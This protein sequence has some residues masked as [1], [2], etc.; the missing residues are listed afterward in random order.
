MDGIPQGAA[1]GPDPANREERVFAITLGAVAGG[2]D[3][4]YRGI[5]SSHHIIRAIPA[6][7]ANGNGHERDLDDTEAVAN[8][9]EGRR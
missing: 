3:A 6:E 1:R 2:W 5:R 8:A 7:R 4:V 9:P